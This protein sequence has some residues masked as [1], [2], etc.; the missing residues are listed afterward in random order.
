MTAIDRTP[1]NRDFLSPL[2]FKL[3]IKKCP[4]VE[5]F[6]QKL[7]VPS[8]T[9]GVADYPNPF[10]N[11]PLPG[12][13]LIFT[14]FEIEFKVDE[15][16][17]NYLE[18]WNWMIGLGFPH[19]FGQ[20]KALADKPIISGEGIYSDLSVISLEGAHNPNIEA[21]FIDAYPVFLSEVE[22]LSTGDVMYVTAQATFRYTLFT[23]GK[24]A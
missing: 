13:H 10:V 19:D 3:L 16:L 5:F 15:D 24:M 4:G 14:P 11:I 8:I 6:S 1:Q 22:Y 20:Y 21:V 9:L 23:L 18:I 7:K 12:D 2:N 17:K